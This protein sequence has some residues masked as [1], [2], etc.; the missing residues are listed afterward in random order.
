MKIV[1]Y[2]INGIR[3][4]KKLG[5]IEWI[6]NFEADIY[7]LQEVRCNEELTRELLFDE[8]QISLF[9][10]NTSKIQQ[11]HAIFNCGEISVG[12]FIS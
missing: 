10:N 1:S 6:E 9:E 7:C 3:A 8:S 5:L 2:N 12:E 11:Y 4:A